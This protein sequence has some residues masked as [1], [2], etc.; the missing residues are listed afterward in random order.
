MKSSTCSELQVTS[1]SSIS[2]PIK[3]DS[4][5]TE[6]N[7]SIVQDFIQEVSS[8]L[9]DEDDIQIIDGNQELT[10]DMTIEV[11]LAHL[12][13]KVSIEGKNTIQLKKPNSYS[14]CKNTEKVR[15]KVPLERNQGSVSKKLPDAKISISLTLQTSKTNLTNAS[16]A[17]EQYL[18]SVELNKVTN[19]RYVNGILRPY[20]SALWSMLGLECC[21]NLLFNMEFD[22]YSDTYVFSSNPKDLS[23]LNFLNYLKDK[24]V[25][26]SD[27]KQEVQDALTRTVESVIDSP[28]VQAGIKKR[29][30]KISDNISDTFERKEIVE[31]FA[32]LD[33]EFEARQNR[34][35]LE[36]SYDK[37]SSELLQKSGDLN[38]SRLSS[39]YMTMSAEFHEK[40]SLNSAIERPVNS[41]GAID[42][43]VPISKRHQKAVASKSTKN[44]NEESVEKYISQE[45][46][47]NSVNE[48]SNTFKQ[49]E[50]PTYY[51]KLKT[52]W[53][54]CN[55]GTNYFVRFKRQRNIK[56]TAQSFGRLIYDAVRP[57]Y[58]R[59]SDEEGEE[60]VEEGYAGN[61]AE[62]G[63]EIE[64][65]SASEMG[66]ITHSLN[67]TAKKLRFL[68]NTIPIPVHDYDQSQFPDVHIIKSVPAT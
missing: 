29:L 5:K 66:K 28:I 19:E 18:D 53:N 49:I 16:E 30:K 13:L 67:R 8:E 62:N 59:S 32:E 45:D 47:L 55:A 2:P 50:F 31:F 38:T 39:Y 52:I 42:V 56:S 40:T 36:M 41:E 14:G 33:K 51:D 60:D 17:R 65:E 9:I 34:R 21:G 68:S 20:G 44:R 4:A 1:Q 54:T 46:L 15:P 27:S 35:N 58:R 24:L 48:T 26:T 37:Y 57:N 61:V 25:F 10:I 23:I 12:F 63:I 43:E 64:D 6:T 7:T 11:E 3:E 22:Y